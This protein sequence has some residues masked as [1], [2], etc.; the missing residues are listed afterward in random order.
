MTVLLSCS[1]SLSSKANQ[2][3]PFTGRE[4]SIYVSI[5]DIRKANSK[6]IQLEYEKDINA[7]LREYIRNDSI[8]IKQ[9]RQE[10]ELLRGKNN[11]V[12]KQRNAAVGGSLVI[13]LLLIM[14]LL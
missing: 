9:A 8:I 13:L 7:S 10:C 11:K 2:H 1:T 6:L 3:V 12:V 14:K 4:D 5:D